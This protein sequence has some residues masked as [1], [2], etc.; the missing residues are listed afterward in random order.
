MKFFFSFLTA[1]FLISCTNNADPIV[2]IKGEW[3]FVN[4][5][6]KMQSSRCWDCPDFVFDK[7]DPILNIIDNTSGVFELNIEKMKFQGLH[8]YTLTEESKENTF[9]KMK[10][11]F[12]SI[13]SIPIDIL[14]SKSRQIIQEL[15]KVNSFYMPSHAT[16]STYEFLELESDANIL[17]FAKTKIK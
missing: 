11:E 8:D 7:A 6:S 16:T 2:S 9:G 10:F 15:T 13:T 4:L 1:C 14:T 12:D 5:F 17:I 3:K